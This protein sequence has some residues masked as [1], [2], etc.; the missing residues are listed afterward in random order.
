MNTFALNFL[1][2]TPG[3]L[4]YNDLLFL[5]SWLSHT[6]MEAEGQV[7]EFSMEHVGQPQKHETARDSANF[8][9][10]LLPLIFVTEGG[11]PMTSYS[12]LIY[13][14]ANTILT[15][16]QNDPDPTSASNQ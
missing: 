16:L 12:Y 14:T 1:Q 5:L 11:I 9:C 2:A 3:G 7:L 8:L 6:P 10:L 13:C 15:F 4:R